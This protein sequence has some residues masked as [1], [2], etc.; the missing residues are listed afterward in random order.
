MKEALQKLRSP[1]PRTD[2]KRAILT[3]AL[4][5]LGS[6]ALGAFSKWLDNL[7]LDDTVF[8]HRILEQLDLGNVFSALPVW[9]VLALAIAVF[10]PDPCAAALRVFLFFIGM[11]GAYHLWT[12]LFSGFDPGSY[13]L[14]WYGITALSPVFALICWYGKGRHPVCVGIDAGILAVLAC[15]CFSLGWFYF[16]LI[17]WM[18]LILFLAAAAILYSSPKQTLIAVPAGIL[19]AFLIR[20]LIPFG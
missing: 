19:L 15:L 4:L 18:D 11:C 9:L 3:A 20:P 10:S 17:S 14:I 6:V 5:F 8:W 12:V 16:G 7:A 2:K 1:K 13:M